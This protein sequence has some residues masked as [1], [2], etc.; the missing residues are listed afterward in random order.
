VNLIWLA[1]LCGLGC[2]S[3]AA[4]AVLLRGR[5]DLEAA[6]GGALGF[7]ALL[8]VLVCAGVTVARSPT[9]G[10]GASEGAAEKLLDEMIERQLR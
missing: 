10:R 4:S 6:A 8:L 1:L 7:V 9:K 3:A 2:L 5:R